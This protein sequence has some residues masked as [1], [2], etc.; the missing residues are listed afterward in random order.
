METSGKGSSVSDIL[1]E[2]LAAVCREHEVIIAAYLFGSH[3]KGSQRPSSDV[4]V[5]VL[6]DE[7]R[8]P[9]FSLLS[10]ALMVE[11]S[12]G[13]RADI[14][15]LNRAGEVLKREVRRT[16]ILVFDRA[17]SARK[18]FEVMGRKT[19]EDF[20]HLHRRYV[21]ATLYKE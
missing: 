5:A 15:V 13:C 4:D 16:G 12:I 17:P 20:L 6:L 10:F 8:G 3:G 18:R 11:R 14:V 21:R 19:Y 2:Q 1:K 9:T 7:K